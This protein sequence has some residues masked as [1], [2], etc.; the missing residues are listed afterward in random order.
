MVI[1]VHKPWVVIPL[2]TSLNYLLISPDDLKYRINSIYNK[3][4]DVSPT[5]KRL[6]QIFT[7]CMRGISD[8]TNWNTSVANVW[9]L[10][11]VRCQ[12]FSSASRSPRVR[13]VLVHIKTF[14]ASN[15]MKEKKS[16]E[17]L[18]K[19][20]KQLRPGNELNSL[21]ELRERIT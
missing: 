10:A 20:N 18:L 7:F 16:L 6:K 1:R 8:V 9:V 17:T 2:Y 14:Q 3:R 21:E 13:I 4:N 11:D 12:I 5:S 19:K 15:L